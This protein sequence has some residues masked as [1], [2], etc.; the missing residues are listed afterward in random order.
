MAERKAFAER[1]GT[2]YAFLRN[3]MY[4]QRKPGEKLCVAIERLSGGIVTRKHLRPM[5]WQEIWPELVG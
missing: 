5:D 4:G 3:V 1:C 2:S